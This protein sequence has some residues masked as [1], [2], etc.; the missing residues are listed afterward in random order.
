MAESATALSKEIVVCLIK[1][2]VCHENIHLVHYQDK[3][4]P[5]QVISC[6]LL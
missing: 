3:I 4:F 6:E 2:L 5:I 1:D